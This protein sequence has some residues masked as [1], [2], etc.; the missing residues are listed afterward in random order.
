M[1]LAAA[2]RKA[3]RARLA[4]TTGCNDLE[5]IR[6]L[7]A[8]EDGVLFLRVGVAHAHAEKEAV[9]LRFRQRERALELDGVLGRED[10][11]GPRQRRRDALDGDLALLHRLEQRG[12][13]ARRRA[14]DLVG[15]HDVRDERAR[16]ELELA[17]F[18]WLKKLMPV[19]SE[20]MRSG[21]NWMRLKLAADGAGERLGQHRLAD[22][23]DVVDEDVALAQQRDERHLDDVVSPDDDAADVLADAGGGVTDLGNGGGMWSGTGLSPCWSFSR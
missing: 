19:T 10:E 12:L 5:G 14:V 3:A 20:G 21:V 9:E 16:A 7:E 6:R 15:E 23:G 1:D 8:D 17:D 4:S 13:G 11:E 2:A 22:A 18:F